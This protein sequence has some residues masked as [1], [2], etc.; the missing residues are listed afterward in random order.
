[1]VTSAPAAGLPDEGV[2]AAIALE[3]RRRVPGTAVLVLSSTWRSLRRSSCWPT[4]PRGL[5]YL[6]KERIADPGEFVEAVRRGRPGG[7]AMDPE[8]VSQLLARRARGSAGR[9]S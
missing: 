3:A 4:A 2:R 9:R 8:V 1:M 5:G 6:L 7:A